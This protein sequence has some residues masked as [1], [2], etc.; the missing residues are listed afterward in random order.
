MQHVFFQFPPSL[1]FLPKLFFIKLKRNVT[2]SLEFLKLIGKANRERIILENP[3]LL[4]QKT[5]LNFAE[6][7]K[8]KA[9]F[10]CAC[11]REA[12]RKQFLKMSVVIQTQ[13]AFL[14][15]VSKAL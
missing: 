13:F 3:G 2:K 7:V 11:A 6:R 4:E 12:T 14:T 8:F 9:F 1:N 15:R 10:R 5:D